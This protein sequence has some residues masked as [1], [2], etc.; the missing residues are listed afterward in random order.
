ME[1]LATMVQRGLDQTATETK[2]LE[3]RM[4]KG[5]AETAT[6]DDHR[7]LKHELKELDVQI[8]FSCKIPVR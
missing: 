3:L 7:A 6:K 5:F 4:Q 1:Q 2:R 8:I